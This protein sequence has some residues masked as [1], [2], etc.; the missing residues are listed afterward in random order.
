MD[1]V[2]V[3]KGLENM[4]KASPSRL[5]IILDAVRDGLTLADGAKLAGISPDTITNW[6]NASSEF[7]EEL[8]KMEAELKKEHIG[9]VKRAGKANWT[10]SAWWLERKHKDEYALKQQV[11][12]SGDAKF[13]ITRGEEN[14]KSE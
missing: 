14:I 11:E 5:K 2:K 13:I 8:E 12:H 6:K 9:N 3:F 10:A 1:E 7:C 4:D